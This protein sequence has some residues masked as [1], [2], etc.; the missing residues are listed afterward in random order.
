MATKKIYDLAVATRRYTDRD[1]KEKSSYENVGSV[2]EMDDGGRMILLKRSFNPAGVPFKDGSDQVVISMFVPKDKE[3]SPPAQGQ[4]STA[5][6]NGYQAPIDG[7][8]VPFMNPYR[9]KMLLCI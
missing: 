9:G 8:D 1:G 3:Q 5:K 7:D 4:H 6:A 2:L